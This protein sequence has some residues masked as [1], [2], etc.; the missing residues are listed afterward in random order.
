MKYLGLDSS[1]QSLSAFIIDSETRAVVYE[2]S[3]NFEKDLPEY[4][5]ENGTIKSKV[6]GEVHSLPL[7]WV[8]AMDRIFAQ[9]KADGAPLGEISAI[10]GSGQQHGSVYLKANFPET[11]RTLAQAESLV[12][13]IEPCL[14]RKTSPI[15]MD[16]ST[17]AECDEI[18]VALG[19]LEATAKATGLK[20]L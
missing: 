16:S 1:T 2:C 5:T 14:S 19:G 17:T 12:S 9:M 8:D 15:W 4:S 20:H 13:A 11:L 18:R 7:M 10:A 6:S 3:L